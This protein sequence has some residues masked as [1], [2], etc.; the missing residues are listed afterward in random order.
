[1]SE[2]RASKIPTRD[3]AVEIVRRSKERARKLTFREKTI[4]GLRYGETAYS[5][6]ETARMLRVTVARVRSLEAKALAKC[7]DG[8][9]EPPK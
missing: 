3:D 2:R 4:I 5:L 6:T 1:M 7:G 8:S 9:K